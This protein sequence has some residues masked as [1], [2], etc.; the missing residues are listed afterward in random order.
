M[1]H[2]AAG[3]VGLCKA[4]LAFDSHPI[5]SFKV[6]ALLSFFLDKPWT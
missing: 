4:W 5:R 2:L 1:K 3:I 6:A